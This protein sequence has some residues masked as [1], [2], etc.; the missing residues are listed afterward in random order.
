MVY[1][2]RQGTILMRLAGDVMP[3]QRLKPFGE[4]GYLDLVELMRGA[5][6]SFANLETTVRRPDQGFPNSTRGTPMST[7]P[8]LLDELTWFGFDIFSCANNHATDYGIGGL[9]ATLDHLRARN[10]PAAGSGRN[11]DEARKPAYLETAAGRIGLIAATSFF[12]PWTRAAPQR[13]DAA[14]R[15]GISP[16]EFSTVYGVDGA[17]FDLLGEASRRLGLTNERARH[18]AMF[19][20][21]NEAPADSDKV[22]NFLGHRFENRDAFSVSTKVNA[23]DAEDVLRWIR[24]AKRQADWVIFSFHSHAF[25]GET[26]LTATDSVQC[27]EPAEFAVDFARAA[28]DAGADVVAGHGPHFTLGV[29]LYRGKPIFYSLGNFIFQ[30]DNVTT[31]PAES[32]ARFGLGDKATPTEFLDART[33]NETRGFPAAAEYWQSVVASCQFEGWA[34]KS[35][36]LHPVDLGFGTPRAQRGRPALAQGETAQAILR[37]M[38]RLSA[39]YGTE[40]AIEGDTGVLRLA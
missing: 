22:L 7:P 11:L 14:G 13:G 12:S 5:D 26:F 1:R 38:A 39:R 17:T 25:G 24:E 23:S 9:L 4:A 29:E 33:G 3:A 8:E 19:F 10:I 36:R 37:R 30:N 2:A 35:V 6:V 16:L 31:F 21:A 28:V 32:F 34:L 15:P 20:S 40:L 27:E 18:R